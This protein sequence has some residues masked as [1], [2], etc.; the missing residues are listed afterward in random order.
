MGGFAGTVDHC[1][2][3]N[4][5]VDGMIHGMDE[6][7][8]IAGSI[9]Y[10]TVENCYT[11]VS[12]PGSLNSSS[13][14]GCFAGDIGFYCNIS[15]CFSSGSVSGM[16]DVGGFSGNIFISNVLTNCY[17]NAQI[18]VVPSPGNCGGFV[19]SVVNTINTFT[20][21]YWDIQASGMAVSEGGIGRTTDEMTYPHAINT[22]VNWDFINVW[23]A[24]STGTISNG[25]P[26][27]RIFN[28]PDTVSMPFIL[29]S[30]GYYADPIITAII[31]CTTENAVIRYT[32]DGND[33]TENS[34]VYSEPLQFDL[35]EG[36]VTLKAR[37]YKT[38]LMPSL[39]ANT[40]YYSSAAN[41]IFVP[42]GGIYDHPISVEIQCLT[43]GANIYYTLDQTTPTE[44]STLYSESLYLT[45]DTWL[46]ARAFK[47]NVESSDIISAFYN[48][49]VGT[50]DETAVSLKTATLVAYPNP[51]N[52][53]TTIRFSL[54]IKTKVKLN[55]YTIKG[56]LVKDLIDDTLTRGF[57]TLN[58]D[59]RNQHGK[60]AGSGLYLIRF[61][62]DDNVIVKKAMMLK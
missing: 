31:Q 35:W 8:G 39:I 13:G 20:N 32:I 42:L 27:L 50:E 59:G 49:V 51:F 18:T 7:G 45:S 36:G 29:P 55:I 4:C 2:I 6:A 10:S 14:V 38:G 44:Q 60:A 61:E 33:P 53:T 23:G 3:S 56:Q 12:M 26:Y 28:M 24:D 34:P 58:W 40:E 21:C 37:A 9:Y 1:T 25:Y 47:Q 5:R 30:G 57:H 54:P 22:Y 46:T 43:P 11:N 19:G 48:I 16:H 52:P 15:N 41:P 62:T 17:S